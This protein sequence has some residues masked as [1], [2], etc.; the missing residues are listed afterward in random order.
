M[1]LRTGISLVRRHR[2]SSLPVYACRRVLH[3]R[4]SVPFID[5]D[6]RPYPRYLLRRL[7]R[8][9]RPSCHIRRAAVRCRRPQRPFGA[10]CRCAIRPA[11]RPAY[12][13][14]FVVSRYRANS[15]PR[16]FARYCCIPRW[17]TTAIC[18]IRWCWSVTGLTDGQFWRVGHRLTTLQPSFGR[19]VSLMLKPSLVV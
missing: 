13:L 8:C 11:R 2:R 18:R 19:G 5:P 14:W 9:S 15:R 12:R 6:L 7:S 1:I 3:R 10:T 16:W 4:S 17:S